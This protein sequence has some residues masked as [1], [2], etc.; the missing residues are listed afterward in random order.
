MDKEQLLKQ[1]QN[2]LDLDL[3]SKMLDYYSDAKNEQLL[4]HWDNSITKYGK[5]LEFVAKAVYQKSSGDSNERLLRDYTASIR[6]QMSLPKAIR[7]YLPNAMEACYDIRN[8]RDAAHATLSVDPN[9]LDCTYVSA[10]CDWVLGELLIQFGGSD[11]NSI[12]TFLYSLTF[13]RLPF[14]YTASDGTPLL[15]IENAPAGLET[16]SLLNIKKRQMT[17]DEICR[18]IPHH[19][20]NNIRTQLNKC[21]IKKQ[22]FQTASATY[23]IL[24]PGILAVEEFLKAQISMP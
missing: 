16:L 15:L 8:H 4:N 14:F 18:C 1:F 21:K 7:L 11:R 6:K 12:S 2:S 24:P 5:F 20:R 10:I 9:M 13:R 17:L 3:C 19:S 22:V 23:E